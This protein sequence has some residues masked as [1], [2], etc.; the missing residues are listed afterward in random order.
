MNDTNRAWHALDR[1]GLLAA[2]DTR[3]EGLSQSEA[4]QRLERFGPNRLPAAPRQP[5]IL[6]FLLQF[7]NVLIYVLIAAAV[8]AGALGHLLDS[9]VI[10]AVVLINASIGFIQEGKAEKAMEAIGQMLALKAYVMRDGRWQDLPAE[11]L[12][13]G[14]IVRIKAGDRIP[15][16]L[17]V[18]ESHG[19]RVDQAALTGESLPVGK[20]AE[21]VDEDTAL[22]DRRCMAYAGS[23]ATNGQALGVIA[24]TGEHTELGRISDLLKQVQK[25]TTP[26]LRKINR[27]ARFLT[28]IIVALAV[29]VIVAGALVHDLPLGEGVLAGIA[30]AVA[31]IPEGLPAIITITLAIG[32]QVMASRQAVVRR[33]PAVETLGS[34]NVICSDKTGTLTANELKARA[35]A[36]IEGAVH[37]E[38]E[39][40]SGSTIQQVIR[41]GVLCNDFDPGA[42]GGDPLDKALVELAEHFETDVTALRKEQPRH[43]LIPFSSEH[44][45][46]A[47]LTA[48]L[49]T[50]KGAPER[51]ISRCSQQLADGQ[52]EALDSE[53]WE[54]RLEDLTGEGLRVLA[55]A[56]KSVDASHRKLDEE[57]DLSDMTLL[58]LVGFADPPRPE[59]PEAVAACQSAGVQVKMITGD[60]AATA[61]AIAA[62]LNINQNDVK[63]VTGPEI[64]RMDDQ[65]LYEIVNE[66]AVFARTTPEHKLRLVTALQAHDLV[67]AMTGDGANDAP[68]LK[69]ADIGVAMGIKGTEASRQAAEMVLADDN[70]ATIVA[71]VEEGRGVYDNI[72]KAI[73]FMLPT[74]AAQSLV[75]ILAVL[76]GISLPITPVQILWVNMAIAVTLALAL[77]FEPLENDVMK[78]QPR[79]LD[80]GLMDSFVIFRIMWVGLLLSLGTFWLYHLV[81]ET[82]GDPDLARTM[83]VNVLVAG[84]I[85]Y[86]FNCRRWQAPSFTVAALTAN[87]WAWLCTGILVFMQLG[88]TY[89]P[90]A[91]TLFS[92]TGMP[93]AYWLVPIA[94]GALVF[95]VVELEKAL[96]RHLGMDWASVSPGS[97]AGKGDRSNDQATEPA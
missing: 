47:V 4:E 39:D 42:D 53:L 44:K 87:P 26:L 46:M 62:E 25:L 3:A 41:T 95:I 86:L 34:V 81:L 88:F 16:D 12:I 2:L 27:F 89:L 1:D 30:L 33:L 43:D 38:H 13:P 72:R 66:T 32:V 9:I 14:D 22:A 51:V 76:A 63:A 15:A 18:L 10:F 11:A 90:P 91:Q 96:T 21:A 77:A 78:R 54:Q 58:G 37:P 8:F 36:T 49:I 69:R 80:Q 59:V 73:L 60:H 45:F 50:L 7:H 75:I 84:Q 71:G 23:M 85:T 56:S 24:V 82:S 83:A 48:S 57:H 40:A 70:F 29:L 67:V 20:D 93:P 6:R 31:A 55:L 97:S 35:L 94:F 74:N 28:M 68:A 64:D 79:P 17:R 5:A 65:Q 92:T 61:L 52:T 19:L